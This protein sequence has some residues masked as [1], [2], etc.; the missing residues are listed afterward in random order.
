MKKWH[1]VLVA[2]TALFLA[3]CPVINMD[4]DRDADFTAYKTFSWKIFTEEEMPSLEKL[5]PILDRRIRKA[6][7]AE[8]AEKGLTK[9]EEGS[10]SDLEIAYIINVQVKREQDTTYYIDM[11]G[12]YTRGP[13]RWEPYGPTTIVH[14]ETSTYEY[15]EGTFILD[16]VDAKQQKLVW[17]SWMIKT[18]E[19]NNPTEEQVKKRVKQLLAKYPPVVKK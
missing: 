4:Y 12:G 15:E 19:S 3:G 5:H 16:M 6:I 10:A 17:Q 1:L 8:L 13:W 7:E 11:W 2:L 14:A 9:A 18:I